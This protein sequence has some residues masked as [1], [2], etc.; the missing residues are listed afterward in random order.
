MLDKHWINFLISSTLLL[1]TGWSGNKQ[2]SITAGS[3]KESHAG[4]CLTHMCAADAFQQQSGDLSLS[5][6]LCLSNSKLVLSL[7]VE[8]TGQEGGIKR[9]YKHMSCFM[10]LNKYLDINRLPPTLSMSEG[11]Y[12]VHFLTQQLK[13]AAW[14]RNI[15]SH[16][17][18]PDSNIKWCRQ[19][20]DL[21]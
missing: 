21:L 5:I 20:K 2:F 1:W 7:H 13:K 4:I 6:K 17:P 10:C 15:I 8:M 9:E 16:E 19:Y 14:N 18:F 3:Q 12:F 11:T